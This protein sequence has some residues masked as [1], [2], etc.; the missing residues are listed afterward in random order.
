MNAA[1]AAKHRKVELATS[2][3]IGSQIFNLELSM[4]LS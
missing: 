2:A 1:I 3:I 4:G